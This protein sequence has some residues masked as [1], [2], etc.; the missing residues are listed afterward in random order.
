MALK[1]D[2]SKS[3][4]R[5]EWELLKQMMAR[6]GFDERWIRLIMNC[7]NTISY[8]VV[9]KDMVEKKFIPKRG[10]C[11]G[12][13]LNPFLFLI[14][15]EGLS[16]LLRIT[17][18]EGL[19]RGVKTSRRSPQITHFLFADDCILFGEA[20]EKG[21]EIFKKVLKEYESCSGQCVNYGKSTV[22]FSSNTNDMV[23]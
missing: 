18:E 1:I 20:S 11:Q 3:Y 13:H 14:C 23:Q 5:V 22:F 12:D 4:D 17:R 9:L 21:T 16:T 8:L 10:L 2:M 6:M 7:I 15:S 19:L